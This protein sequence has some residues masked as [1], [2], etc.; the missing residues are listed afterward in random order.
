MCEF[1]S[2]KEYEGNNYFLTNT[3]LETKEGTKLLKPEVKVDLCGHGA[4]EFFYPELKGKGINKECVDFSTPNNFPKEIVEAL[5][6]G[7]LCNIGIA[8]D[9][10]NI[11]GRKKYDEIKASARKEYDEIEA[12]ARK[13]YDEIEASARKKYDEIKAPA[14]KKYDEIEAPA[15][16]KY[17]EI[18]ASARKKYDEIKAS[19]F[20]SIVRQK[21]YRK[22]VWK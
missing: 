8:L 15:R 10:L 12:S 13:K 14:W 20:A 3:D 1:I 11:E 4:I 18:E 5:K 22:E 9:I 2:W 17:D 16:K 6:N 21:K 7:W 19:A